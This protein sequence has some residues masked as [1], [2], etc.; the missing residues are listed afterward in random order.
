MIKLSSFALIE[1]LLLLRQQIRPS[2]PPLPKQFTMADYGHF[3]REETFRYSRRYARSL[4]VMHGQEHLLKAASNSGVMVNFLHYGSWILAGGGIAHQLDLPYT[5]IASRRNMEVLQP[6]EQKFWE[7]VHQRGSQLYGHPL[8]YTDQSPRL[9]IKWLKTAG[10]ILGVVLD[11]REHSQK[12]EEYPFQFLGHTLF[13]QCGPARLACLADVP[14]VPVTIQ[15]R[16]KEQRHHLFFDAPIFPSGNPQDMTQRA[17]QTIE[18]YVI[19]NP[20]QQFCNIVAEYS[21]RAT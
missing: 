11:V 3:M 13:M 21:Q 12:Y 10:N 9:S 4:I 2:P 20:E 15:Y 19:N 1:R 14:M 16:P 8:F 17:L 6:E 18:K 7:G 5:V